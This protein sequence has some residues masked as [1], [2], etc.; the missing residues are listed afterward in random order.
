MVER[1]TSSSLTP[2]PKSPCFSVLFTSL[3]CQVLR[4]GL[5]VLLSWAHQVR[6]MNS[7]AMS[8][9][10]S[11]HSL[12]KANLLIPRCRFLAAAELAQL[13]AN[14]LSPNLARTVV[15]LYES[16]ARS[17]HFF[18]AHV[19]AS[20]APRSLSTEIGGGAARNTR[21]SSGNVCKPGRG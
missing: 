3:A 15:Q 10:W 1:R 7:D 14:L 11:S 20:C 8:S 12:R 9:R 5:G 4:P 2:F 19:F 17:G 18:S 16:I 21:G 6:L 13:A